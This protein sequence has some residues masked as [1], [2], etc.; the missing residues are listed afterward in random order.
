[1]KQKVL[2]FF[3]LLLSIF[4]IG[5]IAWQKWHYYLSPFDLKRTQGL[6][7]ISQYVKKE[8]AAWIPDE[9]LFS[10]AGWYYLNGGSPI[11]INPENPPLGKYLI[12]LSIRLFNNEKIPSLIFGFLSLFSFYLVCRLFFKNS[13]LSLIPVAFFSWERLFREQFISLPLFETF[14]LTFLNFSL[15]FFIKA[16]KSRWCFLA[17]SFFLGALWA[18]RPWMATIPLI[19]AMVIYLLFVQR[20]FKQFWFWLTTTSLALIV[21]LLSYLKLFL[22]GWSPAKVLSVQKWI[23]WYHQSRLI[24]FGSVWPLIYLNRW[25]VWWGDKP[26]LPMVQWSIFWPIITTLALIFSVLVFFKTI[27]LAKARLKN[28]EFDRRITVLCLWVVFYLAFLSIGNISSRY[29]FYLLPYC[30]LLSYYLLKLR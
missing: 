23:L 12:G 11:L 24:E 28:F 15:Y 29:L 6:Y 1:M 22:E 21:L 20:N 3:L 5:R 27:G 16:G 2:F 4:P 13:W 14:A 17:S 18:T 25:Y 30:Y 26:F 7:E 8:K 19:M 9:T 10:Y